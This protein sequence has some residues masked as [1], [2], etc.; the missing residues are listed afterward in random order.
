MAFPPLML[1]WAQTGVQ[2]PMTLRPGPIPLPREHGAWAMVLTPAVVA[3]LA[4]GPQPVGLAALLGWLAA[5][6]ARGPLE[7]LLGRGASGRAGMASAEPAVA[8]FWLLVLAAVAA[9]LLLPVVLLRPA[10]LVLLAG[11]LLLACAVF[12]LAQRGRARSLLSGFLS[13]TGLMAGAP[14]YELAAAGRLSPAGWA[15]T[16]ACFA[17]FAGSLFRVKTMARER[18]R[19]AFHDLSV[20]VHV[21]FLAG[22]VYPAVRGWAPPLLPLALVPPLVWAVVCAWRARWRGATRLDRVGWSEVYLT[23]LF[24]ALTVLALRLPA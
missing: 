6:A 9:T 16:Y 5:Y 15:L 13:V 1:H 20:A 19:R 14:L 11:A 12:W 23:V 21:A 3:V 18:R 8:R 7:A 24:A 10:V 4:L 2:S 22:A 17:F